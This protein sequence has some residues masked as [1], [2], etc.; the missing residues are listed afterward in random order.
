MYDDDDMIINGNDNA[1]VGCGGHDAV[2][3]MRMKK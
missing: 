1:D 2:L 3:V